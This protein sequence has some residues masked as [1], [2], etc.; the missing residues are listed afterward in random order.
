MQTCSFLLVILYVKYLHVHQKI[1]PCCFSVFILCILYLE[2]QI[3]YTKN[4][5]VMRWGE[6]VT[7]NVQ[8]K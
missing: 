2:L 5:S 6:L 8:K 1:D 3:N 4:M 7:I